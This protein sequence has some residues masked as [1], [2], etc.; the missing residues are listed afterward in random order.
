MN[1]LETVI[2]DVGDPPRGPLVRP[3]D[4]KNLGYQFSKNRINLRDKDMN[5]ILCEL[6]DSDSHRP[7]TFCFLL[8]KRTMMGLVLPFSYDKYMDVRR[9]DRKTAR[10]Q[11]SPSKGPGVQ[12]NDEE[13][14]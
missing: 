4:I 1:L 6:L 7:A 14:D 3:F 10:K 13:E 8:S 11:K 5:Y 9:E 12:A 2:A